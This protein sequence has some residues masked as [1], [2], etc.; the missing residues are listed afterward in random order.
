MNEAKQMTAPDQPLLAPDQADAM[1]REA[2]PATPKTSESQ[3]PDGMGSSHT[4]PSISSPDARPRKDQRPMLNALTGLRLFLALNI[5]NY[6]FGLEQFKDAPAWLRNIAEAGHVGVNLFF[7]MTGFVLSYVYLD[8]EGER[9]VNVR[10]FWITRFTRLYPVYVLGL[11]MWLPFLPQKIQ[12]QKLTAFT[13]IGVLFT[14]PTLIQAWFPGTACKW[15]CPGW[16]ASVDAFFYLI[17]PLIATLLYPRIK[18]NTLGNAAKWIGSLWLASLFPAALYIF[19]EQA[20]EFAGGF[21]FWLAAMKYHPL[22]RLPEFLIGIVLGKLFLTMRAQASITPRLGLVATVASLIIFA[23]LCVSPIMPYPLLHN[24]LLLP[25]FAALVFGIATNYGAVTRFLSW[26]W[27]VRLGEASYCLY[28]LHN[29]I[30]EYLYRG[31]TFIGVDT[32]GGHALMF[33]ASYAVIAVALS[34]L[35]YHNIEVPARQALRQWLDPASGGSAATSARPGFPRPRA[36]IKPSWTTLLSGAALV[37]GLLNLALYGR[38]VTAARVETPPSVVAAATPEATQLIDAVQLAKGLEPAGWKVLSGQW[39]LEGDALTQT[40]EDGYD[41]LAYHNAI[42]TPPY[43][44]RAQFKAIKGSGVGFS[45]N[46][47]QVTLRN[48][49]QVVRYTDDGKGLVWGRYDAEG[50]YVN[51]GSKVDLKPDQTMWP[52]NLHVLEAEVA[53]ATYTLRLDGQTIAESIPL[54]S[55][56]GHVGLQSSLGSVAFDKLEVVGGVQGANPTPPTA[57]N[58]A[59]ATTPTAS[60][61]APINAQPIPDVTVVSGAAFK[62]TFS[63]APIDAG[64]VPSDGEW[65]LEGNAYHQK[66]AEGYDHG[67]F[68]GGSFKAPYTFHVRL[69]HIQGKGGG[70]VFFNASAPGVKKLTQMVRFSDDGRTVLWGYY[71]ANATFVGQGSASVNVPGADPHDLE[72]IVGTEKFSLRLDGRSI[73]RDVSVQAKGNH[74]GLQSSVSAVAFEAVEITPGAAK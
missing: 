28:I 51:Q 15:N 53:D 45:F 52:T 56:A 27:F 14:V 30:W 33:Y 64:W 38:A 62:E 19:A 12:E 29:P 24:G 11:L 46:A 54:E 6:H 5:M 63:R 31:L 59:Q 13:T 71:D 43:T 67:L 61:A 20:G 1:S 74:I 34:Y 42:F 49:A 50:K 8:V 10:R 25:L 9:K 16:S 18:V 7:V 3:T 69:R 36:W 26:K 22:A 4:E 55:K 72:V 2:H 60:S 66:R 37:V 48:G 73:A 41:H 39:A 70:G 23:L 32:Q 40:L 68:Y 35:A 47:P 17:F 65:A 57:Q 44:V 58:T 21:E